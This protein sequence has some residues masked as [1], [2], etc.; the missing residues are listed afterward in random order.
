M[1]SGV[2]KR[3]KEMKINMSNSHL[4]NPTRYWIGKKR[5]EETIKK[6]SQTKKEN[7][8]NGKVI[9]NKNKKHVK[10]QG[11]NHWSKKEKYNNS[12]IKIKNTCKKNNLNRKNKNYDEIY[13]IEKSK[14]EKNNRSNSHKKV[15]ENYTNI[16][17]EKRIKYLFNL[18]NIKPNKSEKYLNEILQKYFPNEWKYVGNFKF[19]L[20]SKNPDFINITNKKIIIE[21]YGDYWHKKEKEDN[22][23]LRIKYFE[24]YG[25]NTIIIWEHELKNK[26]KIIEKISNE[27]K[28][29]INY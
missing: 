22:G 25:F 20:G 15:W 17:K 9:W 11:K 3:T 29:F 12:L 16:E 19:W 5:Y 26:E 4:K 2:Y 7:F 28:R 13:G 21:L 6:I 10:I 23:L 24:K 27:I 14:V 18:C 8:K 1:T